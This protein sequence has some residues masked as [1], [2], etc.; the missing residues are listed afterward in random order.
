MPIAQEEDPQARININMP[1][2]PERPE[3]QLDGDFD[4]PKPDNW[5]SASGGSPDN[6]YKMPDS[7]FGFSDF[8]PIS[9]GKAKKRND[10]WINY[11]APAANI[12]RGIFEK[13]YQ[14]NAGDFMIDPVKARKYSAREAIIGAQTAGKN[15]MRAIKGSSPT[16]TAAAMIASDTNTAGNISRIRETEFNQNERLRQQAEMTNMRADMV[17]Q[18]TKLGI[19]NMNEQNRS[20]KNNLITT[21]L[22]QVQQVA[23]QD[24]KERLAREYIGAYYQ[25]AGNT[26]GE[27]PNGQTNTQDQSTVPPTQQRQA[28][29]TLQGMPENPFTPDITPFV[30]QNQIYKESADEALSGYSTEINS[31]VNDIIG[32][33]SNG[34]AD[35]QN[36]NSSARG[37]GQFIDSTWMAMINEF[38]PDLAKGKSE[39]EILAMKDNYQLSREM[40]GHYANKNAQYLEKRGYEPTKRNIYLAHFLGP[41]G[42]AR[43][44][45]ADPETNVQQV[46]SDSAYKSNPHLKGMKVKDVYAYYDKILN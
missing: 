17:N 45:D 22:G 7:G 35:A 32:V 44:L 20:A 23:S 29:E 30:E 9:G 25:N 14:Y 42:A 5:T 19:E 40:V 28:L 16:L 18:R 41:Y 43:L 12:A 2:A 38:R 4:T 11:L 36:P 8:G 15:T 13:P 46:V 37:A 33:E 34:V 1:P 6:T 26:V 3:F 21:G 31:F 24:A 10:S 39:E 27:I